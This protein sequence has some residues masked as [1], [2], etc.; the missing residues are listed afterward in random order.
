MHLDGVVAAPTFPHVQTIVF[1]GGNE[2]PLSDIR[3]L[4]MLFKHQQQPQKRKI[5]HI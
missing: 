4:Q 5:A 3:Q 1:G 2:F